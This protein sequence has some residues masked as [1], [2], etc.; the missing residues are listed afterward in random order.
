MVLGACLLFALGSRLV[1]I[2]GVVRDDTGTIFESALAND[3]S[4]TLDRASNSLAEGLLVFLLASL[5]VLLLVTLACIPLLRR[6]IE[7]GE[8]CP[9]VGVWF[10]RLVIGDHNPV[11]VPTAT[12]P[13]ERCG[14]RRLFIE[15][16][17]GLRIFELIR[18]GVVLS[19]STL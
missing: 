7:R 5:L 3:A 19:W 17:I 14:G 16:V 13:M 11:R 15:V 10:L 2:D 1:V 9:P 18:R 6:S 8:T 12:C 4:T